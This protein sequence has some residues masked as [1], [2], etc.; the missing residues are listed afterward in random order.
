MCGNA[1][2]AGPHTA[3]SV[4]LRQDPVLVVPPDARVEVR[5][6]TQPRAVRYERVARPAIGRGVQHGLLPQ[7]VCDGK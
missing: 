7:H 1:D 2:N 4:L 5:R 3:Q 6:E